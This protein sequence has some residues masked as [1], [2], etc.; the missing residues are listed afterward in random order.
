MAI[1]LLM[2]GCLVSVV[3]LCPPTTGHR[4]LLAVC[5]CPPTIGRLLLAACCWPPDAGRLLL[6]AEYCR[7][8]SFDRLLLASTFSWPLRTHD[9]LYWLPSI[10]CLLLAGLWPPT[11][12]RPLVP[13]RLHLTA[14][15]WPLAIGRL[16]QAGCRWP[17]STGRRTF[18]AGRK[19]KWMQRRPRS[20][21]GLAAEGSRNGYWWRRTAGAQNPS[22]KPEF[23]WP[24]AREP[25]RSQDQ[26]RSGPPCAT[27]SRGGFGRGELPG[28]AVY[29]GEWAAGRP[30]GLGQ[31]CEPS[32]AR[33]VGRW[34][35]G[36]LSGPG[37]Q[38]PLPHA[39]HAQSRARGPDSAR[40]GQ[41]RIRGGRAWV[42]HATRTH[43]A[44]FSRHT[45]VLAS[46]HILGD[47]VQ[48]DLHGRAHLL[49]YFSLQHSSTGST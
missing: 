3:Y 9:R 48:R 15:S 7:P 35:R 36:S 27:L 34:S 1:G 8:T 29:V 31:R 44:L 37:P 45:A 39:T 14:Y 12:D 43:S 24:L 16:L 25:G 21:A 11:T 41:H 33:Q 5:C 38:G 42:E 10:G 18:L 46:I 4:L 20:A 13:T 47:G 49:R 40:V 23:R 17:R 28:G 32:G 19:G 22:R 6:E 30:H 26:R 2:L